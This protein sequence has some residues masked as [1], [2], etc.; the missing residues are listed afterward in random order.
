MSTHAEK[1][2]C[3]NER[4]NIYTEPRYFE[5]MDKREIAADWA[6]IETEYIRGKM[7]QGD[8]AKEHGISYNTLN[9]H[10]KEGLWPEKR[11]K[12]RERTVKKALT[13]AS[14]RDARK[15]AGLRR[16]AD[17]M[18][19]MLEKALEDPE[20]IYRRTT[21]DAFGNVHD[22]RGQTPEG[23]NFRNLAGALLDLTK[24]IRDLYSLETQAERYEREREER[25]MA[26]EERKV[27]AI[28][29]AEEKP[30]EIRVV[31]EDDVEE[32]SG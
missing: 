16:S 21:M 19:S 12:Y 1:E 27:N 18:A 6:A 24:A 8:L 25:K 28:E 26:L 11:K 32:F 17:R 4:F 20:V 15:L 31:M 13:R 7:S 29:K 2:I 22:V 23:K 14:A 10:A 30:S 9:R 5:F 3:K